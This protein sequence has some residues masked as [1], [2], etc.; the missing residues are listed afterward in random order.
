MNIV[1]NAITYAVSP[2]II[3]IST[4]NS[5]NS[6]NIDIKDNGPGIP[7][8][9]Q[10]MVFKKGYRAHRANK[11]GYGLGLYLAKKLV[12]KQGGNLSLSSDGYNGSEFT[13]R[14]LLA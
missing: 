7:E 3:H 9:E 2:P 5:N 1:D 4:Q 14:L 6:I 11:E 10:E 13:I 12:E 8:Q